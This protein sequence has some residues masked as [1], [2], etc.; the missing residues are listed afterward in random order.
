M[1]T[2]DVCNSNIP[3]DKVWEGFVAAE[4]LLEVLEKFE[5]L[6]QR[7]ELGTLCGLT[8]FEALKLKLGTQKT[9][10]AKEVLDLLDKRAKQKEFMSQVCTWHV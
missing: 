7:L 4:N 1:D 2:T 8:L 9:W 6:K 10:K 3:L 5:I